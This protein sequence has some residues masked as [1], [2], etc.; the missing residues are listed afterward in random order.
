ML[1]FVKAVFYD[2]S[3]VENQYVI[4]DLLLG[5]KIFYAA[6]CCIYSSFIHAFMKGI[7]SIERTI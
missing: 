7:P 1:V 5:Y 4:N 3:N 2:A 6:E